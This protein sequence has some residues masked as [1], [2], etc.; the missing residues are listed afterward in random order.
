MNLSYDRYQFDKKT[1]AVSATFTG[2]ETGWDSNG[3]SFADFGS[4]HVQKRQQARERRL[5]TP[6]WATNDRELRELALRYSETRLYLHDHTG[7]FEERMSRIKAAEKTQIT[8]LSAKLD[9]QVL[10]YHREMTEG[11]ASPE[12]LDLLAEHLQGLDS[13]IAFLQR[14]SV[15]MTLAVVFFYYRL[16]YD[17]TLVANELGIRPPHVR[18]LLARLHTTAIAHLGYSAD[19]GHWRRRPFRRAHR[20]GGKS[21][22]EPIIELVKLEQPPEVKQP[23]VVPPKSVRINLV[24]ANPK[25]GQLTARRVV[26]F[27]GREPIIECVCDC[28]N[29]K[30]V[31]VNNLLTNT[32][33]CGCLRRELGRLKNL[34]KRGE[35]HPAFRQY[36][37]VCS[38]EKDMSTEEVETVAESV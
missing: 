6:Q 26:R 17:S 36:F 34:G 19:E 15:L 11:S 18:A 29:I 24:L 2:G 25:F 14:G 1:R 7:T 13:T 16:F 35:D 22:T 27:Q 9:K 30:N 12:R 8:N 31:T 23:E 4:M 33:S 21:R 20:N 5:K 37:P 32:K 38:D 10:N 3:I 28:G